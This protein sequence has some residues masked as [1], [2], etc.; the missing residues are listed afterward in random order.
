MRKSA[1]TPLSLIATFPL[2][3]ETFKK[4]YRKKSATKMLSLSIASDVSTTNSFYGASL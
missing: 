1:Y 4:Y 3:G 2:T